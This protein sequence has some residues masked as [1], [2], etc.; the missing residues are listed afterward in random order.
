[1]TNSAISVALPV[2]AERTKPTHFALDYITLVDRLQS[3]EL[4]PGVVKGEVIYTL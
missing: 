4:K 2:L 3:R 1:M